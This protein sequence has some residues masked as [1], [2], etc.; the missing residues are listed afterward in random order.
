M[1]VKK[2]PEIPI[3]IYIYKKKDIDLKVKKHE[4]SMVVCACN[5]STPQVEAEGC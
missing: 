2:G 3:I 1:P 4:L 5:P